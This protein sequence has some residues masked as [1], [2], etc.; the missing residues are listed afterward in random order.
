MKTVREYQA[1]AVIWTI[2]YNSIIPIYIF[3]LYLYI[4][5]KITGDKR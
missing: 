4:K 2:T 5:D 1:D 3:L